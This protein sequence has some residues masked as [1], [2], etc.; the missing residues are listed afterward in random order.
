MQREAAAAPDGPLLVVAGAGSGKTRVLTHRVAY[1]IDQKRVSPFGLLA[2]T[3]TNKAASEMKERVAE[4][5]GPVAHRMWVSTFHS[6]CARILRR[7]AA[8][9]G[10]RSSFTI[11]DQAD[12]VRLT[13]YVRRDLNL[14]PKRFPPRRLHSAISALK[15]DLVSPQQAADRAYTPPEHRIAEVYREYQRRLHEASALDFDDLLTKTVEVLHDA[16]VLARWRA[17]SSTCS[18]TSSRTPTPPSG[19][20][21]ASSPRSTA[22]SWSSATAISAS[23]RARSSRWPTARCPI[24]SVEVGDKVLSAWRGRLRPRSSSECTVVASRHAITTSRAVASS[25][26]T[27]TSTSRFWAHLDAGV[28]SWPERGRAL[29][30]LRCARS[31]LMCG[32]DGDGDED[33]ASMW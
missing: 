24:E 20:W 31:A 29:G 1:L 22:T 15:N 3:F 11:Y 33:G 21:S 23:S 13:D 25:P 10:I 26:R 7:E 17:G 27:L 19:R 8:V 6:A 5:V 4:L 9:L 32:R 14:D 16:D 12:A 28:R 2:I 30:R 18:S